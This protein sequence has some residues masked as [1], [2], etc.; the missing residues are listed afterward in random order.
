MP[1]SEVIYDLPGLSHSFLV[2][3]WTYEDF[4]VAQFNALFDP[5]LLLK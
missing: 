4:F 3:R 1:S 5:F 2:V